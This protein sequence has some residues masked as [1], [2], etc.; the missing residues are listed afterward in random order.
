MQDTLIRKDIRERE[1][2]D[3]NKYNILYVDD[4]D[5]N[6]RLFKVTFKRHFNVITASNGSEALELLKQHDIK[7]ILTDQQMPGMLG[8]ELLEK[9]I[10]EFPDIIRI[11]VTGFADISAIAKAVNK[12][13][14]Y[15][16]ITKPWDNGE[17]KITMDKALESYELK[18]DKNNLI[19]ELENVN[20]SLEQK[21]AERTK[22]LT[23]ANERLMSGLIYAE[24]IQ[25]AI[26]PKRDNFIEK[27]ED[28]FI[29]FK[30]KEHVSGDFIWHATVPSAN[31]D[32][33]VVAAIDCVGHGVAGALLT[34]IG[35]SLLQKI[36]N[37]KGTFQP[38]EILEQMNEGLHRSLAHTAN[39]GYETMDGSILTVDKTQNIVYF[40]GASQNLIYFTGGELQVVKGSRL[41]I[42][43]ENMQDL[44]FTQQEIKL[45]E[46]DSLYI[47]SDGY[48]DQLS[49]KGKIGIKRTKELLSR[50]QD[51]S[52]SEQGL[53]LDKF[54]TQWMGE[55]EQ[56][57]DVTLLGLK[58]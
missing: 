18:N 40:A 30:P 26:L 3:A 43:G 4:E 35:E 46:V 22:A 57:D 5:I 31:G 47:Q 44:E 49:E 45:D 53:I 32:I 38:K 11:I 17:L 19:K 36:V 29:I 25:Q 1:A 7:L 33:E 23:E 54:F 52:M 58:I 2:I 6:L 13:G 24:T 51:R 20:A 27:F 28:A 21:V 15:K 37:E 42:G 16:Y 9:T 48:R 56:T 12:C 10:S 8:T 55:E 39:K 34:M 41:H 50:I 14:I